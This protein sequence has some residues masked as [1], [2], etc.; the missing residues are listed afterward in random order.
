MISARV[1]A[2]PQFYDI[3]PMQVVWHGN[4]PRFLELARSALLDR[5]GYNCREMQASGYLWPVVDMRLRYVKPIRLGQRI[6]ISATLL[7]YDN[8]LR[9]RYA[10]T[11]AAA[12]E[13]LTKAETVQ[14]AVAAASNELCLESPRILIER[15]EAERW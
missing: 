13:R 14:V 11:D 5:I 9:I 15:V 8:R 7:E 2:E 10:I 4:Y 1:T 6:A 12:G 3:D